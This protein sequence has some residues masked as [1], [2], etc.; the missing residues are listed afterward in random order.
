MPAVIERMK[1]RLDGEA[2]QSTVAELWTATKVLLGLRYQAE[3][4]NQLL[5]GV[6]AMK[7]STTYQAIKDEGR[8]EGRVEEAREDIRVIG[9]EKFH[10]P[11]PASV[12]TALEGI[13]DLKQLKQ[14][15]RRI[16]VIENWDEL[17]VLT[18]HPPLAGKKK[19][20]K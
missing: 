5:Q 9:E 6:R 13:A 10:V 11:L 14:L 17:L 18:V 19:R 4:V 2:D 20:T 8:V 7:E 15:L 12:Q 3:F 16:L 1:Q